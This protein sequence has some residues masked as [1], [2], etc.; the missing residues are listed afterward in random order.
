MHVKSTNFIYRIRCGNKSLPEY[1]FLQESAATSSRFGTKNMRTDPNTPHRLG[2]YERG[3]IKV[4]PSN[5]VSYLP[6]HT[7][8]TSHVR[9]QR[10]SE[11]TS[12]QNR[13]FSLRPNQ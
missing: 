6:R 3:T 10:C 5:T 1:I 2:A 11:T 12:A 9:M 7:A 4:R 8:V 13:S